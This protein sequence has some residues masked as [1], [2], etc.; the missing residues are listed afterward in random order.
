MSRNFR[1]ALLLLAVLAATLFGPLAFA[2]TTTTPAT[3]PADTSFDLYRGTTIVTRNLAS[4]DA[5]VSAARADTTTRAA[6]ANYSCRTQAS[7][8]TVFVAACPAKP[9]D[10]TQSQICAPPATG[11]WTQ[12]RTYAAA[13]APTCWTAGAWMPATAPSGACTEP[14]PPPPPAG[15]TSIWGGVV[16]PATAAANDTSAVNLGVQF[17]SAMAGQI[18]GIR[19]YKGAGNTGAHVGSLWSATGALL[20][21][22]TFSGETATGW[23]RLNFAAPVPITAGTT[24]TASY[25]APVGRY[26]SNTGYAWPAVAPP[27]T[28]TAG[29]FA[30][31][32]TSA[33]PTL[34]WN[35]SNYWVDVDFVAGATPPPPPPPPA[36]GTASL[37]WDASTD[38]RTIGYRVYY[39]TAPRV[40]AQA[41]GFG[42]L[43]NGAT[44]AQSVVS[45]LAAGT[46]YF[47]VTAISSD[48]E[49][50]YSTEAAKVVP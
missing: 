49:S 27:L 43:V 25:H 41:K 10:Q 38:A 28:A 24:Y 3:V 9:A 6:G 45:N 19:F 44:N 23:Q 35:A 11:T 48:L 16:T 37:T 39:G 20:A 50:D 18:T 15:A 14:P 5:C 12:T 42:V 36:V 4:H 30:Y 34:T 47:A 31:A 22:A 26:A 17:T 8:S 32:P 7:F 2:Q 29:T 40:Y 46:Y 13:P 1:I 33:Y 21:Q